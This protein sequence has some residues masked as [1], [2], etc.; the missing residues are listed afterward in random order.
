MKRFAVLIIFLII[1]Q[2]FSVGAYE[3]GVNSFSKS[4]VILEIIGLQNLDVKVTDVKATVES[5]TLSDTY[6]A[7]VHLET[8]GNKVLVIV[9]ITPIFEDY[10][11]DQVKSI[12]VS[13]F[14]EVDGEKEEF[15]KRV[16]FR[17]QKSRQLAP[18]DEES[19][20]LIYWIIGLCIVFV[21]IILALF[22][23]RPK[24]KVLSIQKIS[25]S[26]KKKKKAKKKVVSKKVKKKAKK[27]L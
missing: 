3:V 5:E 25:S 12:A 23:R 15:G 18:S 11:S 1:L 6:T 9:D 21:F 26:P 22:Y 24:G 27:R 13:G 10:S 7:D 19:S 2:I 20:T 8:E 4:E 14:I 17:E 16:P